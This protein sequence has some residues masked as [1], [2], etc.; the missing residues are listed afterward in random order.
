MTHH[1]LVIGANGFVGSHLCRR[2]LKEGNEVIC[3]DN[4]FTGNKKNILDKFDT[5][6]MST[7]VLIQES[8]LI[9]LDNYNKKNINTY[10]FY[11]A[12]KA[13]AL[14]DLQQRFQPLQ[15]LKQKSKNELAK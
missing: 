1:I 5:S 2:L 4:F 8:P 12:Y 10:Q 13:I 3:L 9:N 15:T 14:G 11:Q 7:N 6:G